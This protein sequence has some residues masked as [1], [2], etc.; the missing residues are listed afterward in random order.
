MRSTYCSVRANKA[1]LRLHRP[2]RSIFSPTRPLLQWVSA[3]AA[4]RRG[5]GAER[6]SV[7]TARQAVLLPE[8]DTPA[9]CRMH[10]VCVCH[11]LVRVHV[12][13]CVLILP[14]YHGPIGVLPVSYS[15]RRE[16]PAAILDRPSAIRGRVIHGILAWRL[17]ASTS[18]YS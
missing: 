7:W 3:T 15:A 14:M 13:S 1:P 9:G 10:V 12:M 11:M 18:T 6:Q 16:G 8:H 17:S 2:Q 4:A 5:P